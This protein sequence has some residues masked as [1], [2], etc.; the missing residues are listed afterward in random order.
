MTRMHSDAFSFHAQTD[1]TLANGL[2][3]SVVH[4][5]NCILFYRERVIKIISSRAEKMCSHL[6]SEDETALCRT[7]HIPMCGS[8]TIDSDFF[9]AVSLRLLKQRQGIF[10]GKG[11][12]V[13]TAGDRSENVEGNETIS[14][15]EQ[16]FL[17][18]H[19]V[20][21]FMF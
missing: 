7:W 13:H 8:T 19:V 16:I 9:L 12:C 14:P 1:M 5:P 20:I 11:E 4:E 6:I 3:L 2:F 15:A 10:L 21:S 18:S 17:C